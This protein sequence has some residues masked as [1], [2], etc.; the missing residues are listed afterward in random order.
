[1]SG[2][3]RPGGAGEPGA[4]RGRGADRPTQ[5][6]A[7]PDPDHSHAPHL[8]TRLAASIGKGLNNHLK[9]SSRYFIYSTANKCLDYGKAAYCKPWLGGPAG[10]AG[11]STHSLG[12]NYN[13]QIT[14]GRNR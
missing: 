8:V 10:V 11:C 7:S 13:N 6:R 2:T 14:V 3:D 5:P 12:C 4:G 9:G 1:M